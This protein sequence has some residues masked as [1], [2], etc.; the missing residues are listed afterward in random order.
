MATQ[1]ILLGLLGVQAVLAFVTHRDTSAVISEATPLIEGGGN[2]ITAVEIVAGRDGAE[3]VSL[4]SVNGSWVISSEENYPA[5]AAKVGEVVDL[6]G[7]IKLRTPVAS[8]ATSHDKLKVSPDNFGRKVEVSANGKSQ[9]LYIGSA[10]SKAVYLRL[11]GSDDVYKIKGVS[12]FGLKDSARSFWSSEYISLPEEAIV[13]F[14]IANENTSLAFTKQDGAWAL[15]GGP[16]GS[17]V[18]TDKLDEL[19]GKAATV[20]LSEPVGTTVSPNYGLGTVRIDYA[21]EE[22]GTK[23]PGS[24]EIGVESDGKYYVKA[25]GNDFVVL[26]N[27]Y[28]LDKLVEATAED[29]TV[30]A[31]PTTDE[32]APE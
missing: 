24:F 13:S 14:S 12:E 6:L 19:I 17:T 29:L 3:A 2:A 7:G 20:R 26:A 4:E 1:K 30:S 22:G 21:T 11:D 10:A 31:A 8:Q 18:N 25:D 32:A 23:L 16:E 27:K 9:T 15:V 5:D 28:G